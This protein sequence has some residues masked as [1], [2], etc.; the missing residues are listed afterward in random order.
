LGDIQNDFNTTDYY[1]AAYLI[2][3]S[4]DELCPAQVF[5]LRNS[6]AGYVLPPGS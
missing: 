5:Q 2:N 3:Q 4:V 6:V 1:Q